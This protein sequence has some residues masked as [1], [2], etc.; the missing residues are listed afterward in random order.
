MAQLSDVMKEI[1]D[2][3]HLIQLRPGHDQLVYGLTQ[4]ICC[5][6][7]LIEP[8]GPGAARTLCQHIVDAGL[9]QDTANALSSAC[10]KRLVSQLGAVQPHRQ[11]SSGAPPRDQCIR[12]VNNYLTASDWHILDDPLTP[13]QRRELVVACRLK[14]LGVRRAS[15]DGLIKWCIVILVDIEY[16]H[17]GVWMS[18][19]AVYDKVY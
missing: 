9:P 19:H 6:V 8:W 1:T 11:Q 16:T 5:K 4:S 14:R 2:A 13:V 12:Y 17:T 3:S 10:D 7:D 15:E 18:Y